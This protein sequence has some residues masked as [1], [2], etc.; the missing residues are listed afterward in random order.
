MSV[1]THKSSWTKWLIKGDPARHQTKPLVVHLRAIAILLEDTR[2][3]NQLRAQGWHKVAWEDRKYVQD[4]QRVPCQPLL[5]CQWQHLHR[6][7]QRNRLSN[8]KRSKFLPPKKRK[9]RR[10]V[11]WCFKRMSLLRQLRREMM[12]TMKMISTLLLALLHR[13]LEVA[14][15]PKNKNFKTTRKTLEL[16]E[17]LAA[18][19]RKISSLSP[20]RLEPLEKRPNSLHHLRLLK[21]NLLTAAPT[22][23]Q[24]L[25][26]MSNKRW[27]RVR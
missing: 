10:A 12:T 1:R 9:E 14:E 21:G 7:N 6:Q 17:V 18:K 26:L 3:V 2:F 4:L 20:R 23:Q 13:F 16:M 15:L 27:S 8:S 22:S 11:G 19:I 25:M 5:L 24:Q